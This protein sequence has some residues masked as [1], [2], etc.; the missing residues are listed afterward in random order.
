MAPH[1][2][3]LFAPFIDLLQIESENSGSVFCR[4]LAHFDSIILFNVKFQHAKP[5][6][7]NFKK[8]KGLDYEMTANMYFPLFEIFG[9]RRTSSITSPLIKFVYLTNLNFNKEFVACPISRD[10]TYLR[11]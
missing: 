1:F 4:E 11:N 5:E 7:F 8:F 9:S 10:N 3:P 2:C 6:I